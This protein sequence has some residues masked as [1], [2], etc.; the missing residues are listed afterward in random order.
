[1][2]FEDIIEQT[3]NEIGLEKSERKIIHALR[4]Y[5]KKLKQAIDETEADTSYPMD[6]FP[7]LSDD[8]IKTIKIF[9]DKTM[10][11]HLDRFSAHV[12]RRIR[13]GMFDRLCDE[14]GLE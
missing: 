13:E 12:A 8:Q 5:E 7:P 4:L 2:T 9:F 6:I 14:L 11:I 1:M 10:K 3:D